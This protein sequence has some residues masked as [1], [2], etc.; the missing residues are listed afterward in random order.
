MHVESDVGNDRV[1]DGG[2]EEVHS[3]GEFT[4]SSHD[5]VSENVLSESR[6]FDAEQPA[7]DEDCVAEGDLGMSSNVDDSHTVLDVVANDGNPLEDESDRDENSVEGKSEVSGPFSSDSVK[8]T[9]SV[10][11]GDDETEDGDL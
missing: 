11:V 9:V 8:V 5:D 4:E 1:G 7:S 2:S 6:S 3:R 10:H